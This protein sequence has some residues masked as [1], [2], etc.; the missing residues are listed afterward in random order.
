MSNETIPAGY[1]QDAR[2]RLIP[3]ARIKPI[4]RARDE[5]V[6]ELVAGAREVNAVLASYKA[7]AF[8]DIAAFVDLSAGEYGVHLGGHKGNVSL[9]SFDG[10]H[11]V[12]RAMAEAIVFDE[13]L[14]AAKVL[15]D[16]CLRDWTEGARSE[17][18]TLIS[19][20]FR[21]D[22]A[23]NI[24]TGSVLALRRLDIT[25]ERWQRAMQAIADAVQVV[26]SKAYVRVY[27]RDDATGQ[28]QPIG[29]DITG[30]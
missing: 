17:L 25:D 18:R 27:E 3:E 19:D 24:R 9:L 4:D 1:R 5:L 22:Q 29:L 14:Q 10:R 12:I 26:G 6:Q 16:E 11:K 2:G 13:R 20:A 21:V 8:G 28:Y 15:I 7:K 23:G 30:V